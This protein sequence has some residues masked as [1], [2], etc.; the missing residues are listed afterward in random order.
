MKIAQIMKGELPKTEQQTSIFSEILEAD[1]PPQEKS[2]QRLGEE[3]QL[4]LGAGLETTGWALSTTAFHIIDQPSV[5]AKLRA[6][7]KTAIPNPNA[8][9]D[10]LQLEKLPYLS[11]CIQEGIRLSYGVSA[12][13]PRVSPNKATKYKAWD[14]PAGTPVSMTIVD[15]HN[16]ERVFPNSRAFV[17]ERW[18]GNPKTE[19]GSSLNRYFVAFGK[20]ARSCLGI[21]YV[22]SSTSVVG[23]LYQTF[24]CEC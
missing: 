16:D 19:N 4:I 12:R 6:E 18:L 15:V 22:I 11:A 5:F 8:Q 14:I 9:L 17:P 20:G 3:A 21:K 10:W 23:S 24:L 13:N 2:V 7:L 1:I